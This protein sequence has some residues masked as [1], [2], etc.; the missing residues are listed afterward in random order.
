MRHPLSFRA[1]SNVASSAVCRPSRSWLL[2]AG[3]IGATPAF[4]AP[5]DTRVVR[6]TPNEEV[7]QEMKG[8]LE[9]KAQTFARIGTADLQGAVSNAKKEIEVRENRSDAAR[10]LHYLDYISCVIIYQDDRLST[11]DKLE[12]IDKIKHALNPNTSENS[13]VG[14]ERAEEALSRARTSLCLEDPDRAIAE[15]NE[16]IRIDPKND[17]AVNGRGDSFFAKKDYDRAI[18]DYS[19]AIRLDPRGCSLSL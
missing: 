9:G 19:E 17:D 13:S 8:N 5:L 14:S 15:Y 16:A 6:G 2:L 12:R 7:S 1:K 18:E 10:E 4:A 11:D 3:V